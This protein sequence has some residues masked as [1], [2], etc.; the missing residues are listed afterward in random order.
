MIAI[1]SSRRINGILPHV[2][3]ARLAYAVGP[4]TTMP[5]ASGKRSSA[6]RHLNGA[7]ASH[8]LADAILGWANDLDTSRLRC[9]IAL[10]ICSSSF[11]PVRVA[12]PKRFNRH[13][14]AV[15]GRVVS[16][17]LL[18]GAAA[19]CARMHQ[20]RTQSAATISRLRFAPCFDAVRS[21]RPEQGQGNI[22]SRT[23]KG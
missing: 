12:V 9:E 3:I 11:W 21:R 6:M 5:R 10:V 22:A 14:F 16:L 19:N 2:M 23:C 1:A 15:Y 13:H 18:Y 17:W 7:T 8:V 20:L 4:H